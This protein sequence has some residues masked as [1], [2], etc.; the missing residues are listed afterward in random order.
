MKKKIICFDLDNVICNT[1]KNYYSKSTP[2]KNVIKL[3]NQL[4]SSD[5]RI[6]IFTARG[7]GTYNSNLKKVEKKFR[8]LTEN[9]LKKW[10]VKYHNLILGKP[11]FD[12]YIDDKNLGFNK[13]W[14][15]NFNLK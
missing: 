6:L 9:Q 13:N 8:K 15:K 1:K 11:S 7:M 3:I 2:K 10:K 5:H 14:Y 12:I 4:Y